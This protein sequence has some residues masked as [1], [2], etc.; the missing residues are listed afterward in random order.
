MKLS[1]AVLLVSATI[2]SG[3]DLHTIVKIDSGLVAGT[4]TTVRS[5]KGIPYAAPPTGKLRWTPPEPAKT[6]TGVRVAK[7]FPNNCPQIPL[8]AGPQS[9]DCLGLNVWTPAHS[10]SDKLPVMVWIHGGGFFIG[11]S[12]QSAYD[13]EPLAVQGVVV[14]SINYRLGVFGF[15]AHPDLSKESTQGVSG[16]YGLLDMI[17][18]LRWVNR[19]ISAFGGDPSNVTIFGESAGGTAVCLLMVLPDAKG[20]FQR[21]ISESA[22]W[23]NVPLSRLREPSYGRIAAEQFGESWA[24][25]SVRYVRKVPQRS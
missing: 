9:E 14:V 12:A 1:I 24:R 21:V 7:T 25:I 17:A 19:N 18:A 8:I 4:G 13:G 20:L 22:A 2:A 11:S 5:Y 10:P 15:L 6:W 16:N 23:I 3:S